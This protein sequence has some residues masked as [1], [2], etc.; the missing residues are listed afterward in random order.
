MNV[1]V[2]GSVTSTP[3]CAHR[4]CRRGDRGARGALASA[5]AVDALLALTL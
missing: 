1:V 4:T 5:E 2:V 3:S